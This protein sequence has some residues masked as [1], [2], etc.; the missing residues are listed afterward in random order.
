[1]SAPWLTYY[2]WSK[3]YGDLVYSRFFNQ[4]III[5]NSEKIAKDLLEDRSSNY[6]DRPNVVTIRYFNTAFMPYGDRWRLQR[7]FLHQ[8]LKAG[9]ASRFVPVQQSKAHELLRRLL[10][11]RTL[12]RSP[13]P[14]RRLI[15]SVNMESVYDYDSLSTNDHVVDIIERVLKMVL[16]V[17]SPEVTAILGAFPIVLSIP[18]WF[19]GMGIK[20][21]AALCKGW[22][23]EWVELP[24]KHALQRMVS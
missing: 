16:A 10:V 13:V 7:R 21:N 23:K 2:E 19:P 15:S 14:V 5:I 17:V 3:V 20:R 8:S 12:Y 11:P 18:S 4:D 24:F 9:S 22:A 6:S 1:A